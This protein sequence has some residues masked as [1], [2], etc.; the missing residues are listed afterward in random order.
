MKIEKKYCVGY[1]K[2]IPVI[3]TG[4]KDPIIIGTKHEVEEWLKNFW[5]YLY[6][7]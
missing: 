1:P 2:M 6:G 5:R 4:Q 7:K 3:Y